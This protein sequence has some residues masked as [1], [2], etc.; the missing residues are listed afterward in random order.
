MNILIAERGE[1]MKSRFSEILVRTIFLLILP[2]IIVYCFPATIFALTIIE[3]NGGEVIPS[4]SIY[5]IRWEASPAAVQFDLLYSLNNGTTWKPVTNNGGGGCADCHFIH[6]H[7]SDCMDCHSVQTI[8]TIHRGGCIDCH[9]GETTHTTTM[10]GSYNWKVPCKKKN[11]LV[12]VI[13]YN[14]S[15]AKI[16]EDISDSTATIEVVR[17]ISPNGGQSL[18][19]GYP[20]HIMWQTNCTIRPVAREELYYTVGGGIWNPIITLEGNPGNYLWEVPS[21]SSTKCKAKVI[22]KDASGANIG[23]DKSDKVFTILP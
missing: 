11:C 1:E 19:S 12:K 16:G 9:G 21:A 10:T 17:L 23:T 6:P 13:G 22:L 4:G 2:T 5:T 20:W 8:H 14:S 15:D 7:T 3:P 18:K